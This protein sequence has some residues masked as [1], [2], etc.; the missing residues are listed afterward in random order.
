MGEGLMTVRFILDEFWCTQEDSEEFLNLMNIAVDDAKIFFEF[1]R[2]KN[3]SSCYIL[4]I[5]SPI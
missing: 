2:F 5:T 4:K 3:F 1:G